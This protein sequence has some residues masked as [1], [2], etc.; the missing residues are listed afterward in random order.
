M[1]IGIR[2]GDTTPEDYEKIHHE[3]S[4]EAKVFEDEGRVFEF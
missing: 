3:R 4:S 1:R 2:F